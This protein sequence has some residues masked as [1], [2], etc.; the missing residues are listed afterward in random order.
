MRLIANQARLHVRSRGAVLSVGVS[1][2][3]TARSIEDIRLLLAPMSH[4]AGAIWIDY[5]KSVIAVTDLELQGLAIPP[6]AGG[7]SVPM[8]WA[9]GDEGTAELW[10]RQSLRLALHGHRRFV[11][12]G[13]DEAARWAARELALA[14]VPAGR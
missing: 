8:A 11:A 10:A 7:R 3:V 2:L 14:P 13:A 6:A 9:V 1:G 12:L 4:R 5:T